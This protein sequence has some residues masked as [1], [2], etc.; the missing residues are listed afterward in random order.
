MGNQENMPGE[1]V[2]GT[3]PEI[4]NVP[5]LIWQVSGEHAWQSISGSMSEAYT[6]ETSVN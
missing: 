5:S 4:N 2:C 6:A 3:M 1:C